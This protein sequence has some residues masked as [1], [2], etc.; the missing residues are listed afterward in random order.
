MLLLLGSGVNGQ[1]GRSRKDLRTKRTGRVYVNKLV[2]G[3]LSWVFHV[4]LDAEGR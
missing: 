3:G 1:V 2:G 4:V